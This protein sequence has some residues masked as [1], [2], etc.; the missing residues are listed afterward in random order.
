[1]NVHYILSSPVHPEAFVLDLCLKG[2][3]EERMVVL[4]HARQMRLC[5]A[6][7]DGNESLVVR[8]QSL[9]SLANVSTVRLL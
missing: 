3:A 8:A 9:A 1:M 2:H 7:D 4:V 6:T 5:A